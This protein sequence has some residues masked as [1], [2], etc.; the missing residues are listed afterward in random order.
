MIEVA[1]LW[2]DANMQGIAGI[3]D[4]QNVP[5]CC[6]NFVGTFVDSISSIEVFGGFTCA[7][8]TDPGC[9]GSMLTMQSGTYIANLQGT[10]WQDSI[11]SA[12]CDPA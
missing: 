3:L 10:A 9:Q 2:T 5:T 8:F 4:I 6:L 7:F 1:E 12:S 11:S